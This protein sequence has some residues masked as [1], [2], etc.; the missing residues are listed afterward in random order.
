MIT[1]K[2]LDRMGI[3]SIIEK[4][5][6]LDNFYRWLLKQEIGSI[7]ALRNFGIAIDSMTM[8]EVLET[9]VNHMEWQLGMLELLENETEN[10]N[11]DGFKVID[12]DLVKERESLENDLDRLKKLLSDI[13]GKTE[14][15][16][17]LK[18]KGYKYETYHEGYGIQ[19]PE[20]EKL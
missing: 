20:K 19:M 2:Q 11:M 18:N 17:H 1:Q 8:K 15:I 10:Q 12:K 13:E 16:I 6:S 3:D 4:H 7:K 5:G 14:H 9:R